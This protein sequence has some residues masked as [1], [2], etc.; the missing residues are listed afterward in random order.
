MAFNFNWSRLATSSISDNFHT[1]AKEL[2]T[3]A[4]NRS[5][6]PS[7]IVDSDIAVEGLELG[8][9][10][11]ELEVLEISDLAEDRFRGV[12]RFTY[13]GN[14]C[15]TLKA[16]VQVNPLCTYLKTIPDFA[17][18]QPLSAAATS[19]RIPVELTLSQFKLCGKV[20]VVY[21]K[22]KGITLV[23]ANDP[24]ESVRVRSSFDSV[25]FIKNYLQEEVE[26]H[27][28]GLFQSELPLAVYKLSLRLLGIAE[29]KAESKEQPKSTTYPT[30]STPEKQDV[31]PAV[32]P[33]EAEPATVESLGPGS[34]EDEDILDP[35]ELRL[36]ALQNSSKTLSLFT[37][38]LSGV[39][40]Q[41]M[42]ALASVARP[43]IDD[44]HTPATSGITTPRRKR[45]HR[46]VNLR[47]SSGEKK[48]ASEPTS[49]SSSEYT[50]TAQQSVASITTAPTLSSGPT[51]FSL[52]RGDEPRVREHTPAKP[53][54]RTRLQDEKHAH[55]ERPRLARNMDY[56]SGIVEKA[57]IKQFMAE[58]RRQAGEMAMEMD[59]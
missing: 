11:P 39:L 9:E 57:F 49:E 59:P 41:A 37:P 6:N 54:R 58:M 45:K 35:H 13:D 20:F 34:P 42:P 55:E 17:S 28:R 10:A 51:R 16:R 18:P 33:G 30:I 12:L 1:I 24:L 14:A 21:S 25:P 38:L 56:E 5:A 26:K 4:L 31:E 48:S 19:L 50:S 43:T 36:S 15:M 29:S 32:E 52:V 46:I 44:Q 8:D 2:L 47:K 40:Y 7:V 22:E 3:E 53:I 27:V 23:F